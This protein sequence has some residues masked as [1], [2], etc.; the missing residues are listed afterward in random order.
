MFYECMYVCSIVKIC[1]HFMVV[2]TTFKLN[3][4][5]LC[6]Q[7]NEENKKKIKAS[8]HPILAQYSNLKC[9]MGCGKKYRHTPCGSYTYFPTRKRRVLKQRHIIRK[10]AVVPPSNNVPQPTQ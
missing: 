3:V 9:W 6:M 4:L 5:H 1:V 2:K 8:L 7:T 10:I